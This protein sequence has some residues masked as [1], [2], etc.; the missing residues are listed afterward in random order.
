MTPSHPP[1]VNVHLCSDLRNFIVNAY[2]LYYILC[3]IFILPKTDC[4]FAL[5]AAP[6]RIQFPAEVRRPTAETK[7]RIVIS[8]TKPMFER[9]IL[10]ERRPLVQTHIND[11]W[12]VLLDGDLKESGIFCLFCFVE[13]Q[14]CSSHMVMSSWLHEMLINIRLETFRPMYSISQ[15]CVHRWQCMFT[16]FKDF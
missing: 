14:M 9:R 4:I 12:F 6:E 16:I 13:L 7:K 1:N 15:E 3:L 11:D 8:E 5:V 2:V 10:E